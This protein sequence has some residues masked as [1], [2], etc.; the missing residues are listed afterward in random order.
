ML[1]LYDYEKRCDLDEGGC[2]VWQGATSGWGYPVANIAGRGTY[3]YLHKYVYENLVGEVPLG[4]VV[5]HI[6]GNPLCLNVEHLQILTKQGNY[7]KDR[8]SWAEDLKGK[9]FGNWKVIKK[10]ENK[11]IHA[12]WLCENLKTGELRERAAH[13]IKRGAKS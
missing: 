9:V 8:Q 1:K 6:C 10:V 5:D 3:T 7:I 11:G 4:Y 13:C 12:G 2:L